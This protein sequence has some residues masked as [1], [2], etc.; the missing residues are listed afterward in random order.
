MKARGQV[1]P[2]AIV[3]CVEAAT[4]MPF[5]EGLRFERDRFMGLMQGE[6]SAALRHFFFAERQAS[7]I[8]GLARD[9]PTRAVESVGIIGGGTMGRS[10]KLTTPRSNAA[11]TS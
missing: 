6:Q 5:D 11:S 10:S 7:K 8:E 1:A 3:D 2:Q 4:T 9:A